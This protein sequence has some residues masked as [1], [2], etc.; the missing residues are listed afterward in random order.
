MNSAGKPES[1]KYQGGSWE[2]ASFIQ[3]SSGGNKILTWVTDVATTRKTVPLR[4]R[5]E[6]L[7]I[8][9]RKNGNGDIINEQ[10]IRV[11]TVFSDEVWCDDNNW[12]QI[13][14]QEQLSNLENKAQLELS[15]D[16][17]IFDGK[18]ISSDGTEKENYAYSLTD[19]LPIKKGIKIKC[20]Y[21]TSSSSGIVVIAIY[22]QNKTFLPEES[23]ASSSYSSKNLEI[24][25]DSSCFCRIVLR[26]ENAND[27][28]YIDNYDSS[29][30]AGIMS[31]T[32]TPLSE[33]EP[34]KN[35]TE[36]NT[37]DINNIKNSLG[38]KVVEW[39]KSDMQA[40]W[41]ALSQ[42]YGYNNVLD[43]DVTIKKV[44]IIPTGASVT[45]Y[46]G[47]R[48][49][50]QL[51][52][53]TPLIENTVD[54]I[55]ELKANERITTSGIRYTRTDDSPYTISSSIGGGSF[56][57]YMSIW[58]EYEALSVVTE[59]SFE[60]FK[61]EVEEK[62]SDVTA[63]LPLGLK[64]SNLYLDRHWES[65]NEYSDI[66]NGNGISIVEEGLQF[67][68]TACTFSNSLLSIQTNVFILKVTSD[69]IVQFKIG[70]TN[71]TNFVIDIANK[72]ITP[73]PGI[74]EEVSFP[75]EFFLDGENEISLTLEFIHNSI[76][77]I[78]V[79]NNTSL[80]AQA[81]TYSSNLQG[82][83]IE[84]TVSSGTVIMKEYKLLYPTD[85]D[86]IFTGDS[87][88]QGVG[89]DKTY[90]T[91][92][93]DYTGKKI[94]IFA[95]GG[96]TISVGKQC[97][98]IC[99]KL[100]PGFISSMFGMNG[101]NSVDTFKYM[102]DKCDEYQIPFFAHHIPMRSADPS[103]RTEEQNAIVEQFLNEY[104][105][106]KE[107][108]RFDIATAKN[109]DITQGGST[110]MSPDGVHPN[111]ETHVKMFNRLFIDTPM[112]F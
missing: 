5:K 109:G 42:R 6:L 80:I 50:Y 16:S 21:T 38:N 55:I 27:I 71:S 108:A 90:A 12:E 95:L 15:R 13:P 43:K 52:E 22:D 111:T 41:G 79:N 105:H 51:T 25:S 91:L 69:T 14:N 74:G 112:I 1:W 62:I 97:V 66:C 46:L 81:E 70:G 2:T 39:C 58:F 19:Y 24:T 65:G 18:Y 60:E 93:R 28:C 89:T 86:G 100:K 82:R 45:L 30:L 35:A 92:Y 110:D 26:K 99:A 64:G 61:S 34:I 17:F 85:L 63:S 31:N 88:T 78:L 94:A 53:L 3:E 72:K 47:D 37:S 106:I 76:K 56:L 44:H 8:S 4:E 40:S 10:Y 68:S 11:G 57:G 54:C 102:Q 29:T 87:I 33:F 77:A 84:V 67:S 96:G 59:E 7:Q 9:Y 104:A 36:N 20:Q 75:E 73:R 101:G 83:S 107:S 48:T 49:T 23:T 98:D 103:S 32:L